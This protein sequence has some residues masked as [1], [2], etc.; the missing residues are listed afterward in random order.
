M[1][2]DGRTGAGDDD[3]RHDLTLTNRHNRVNKTPNG[4][5]RTAR[6]LCVGSLRRY[7]QMLTKM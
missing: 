4:E 6:F 5:A 2:V 3:A 7:A 1:I